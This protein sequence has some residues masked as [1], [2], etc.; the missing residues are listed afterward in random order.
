MGKFNA[1]SI[2]E[3]IKKKTSIPSNRIENHKSLLDAIKKHENLVLYA[4]PTNIQ[5][6]KIY[7]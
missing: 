3:W 2:V 7:L 1:D 4:G 6:F 5:K